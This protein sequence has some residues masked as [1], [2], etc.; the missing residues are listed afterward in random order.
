M[1][2]QFKKSIQLVALGVSLSLTTT[3]V[4][5]ETLADALVSAYN[6]SGLLEQNRALL[7]AADEDVASASSALLPILTWSASAQQSFGTNSTRGTTSNIDGGTASIALNAQMMLYDFGGTTA[8]IESARETV[9]ATRAQLQ[10]IEQQILLRGATAYFNLRRASKFVGLR[11]NNLRLLT[12][13][14]RA[15][16]D[17]FDVGEIT[18]TD[19]ALAESRLAQARSGLATAQGDL[20]RA[21]EEYTNVIGHQPKSLGKLPTLPKVDGNVENAKARAVRNHPSMAAAQHQVAAVEFA[22][23]RAEAAMKP[24]VSLNSSIGIQDNLTSTDFT[25]SASIGITASGPIYSGGRLSSGVRRAMAQRDAMRGNL[26]MVRHGVQ[27]SVGNA[28]AYYSSVNAALQA[29]Q[30]Q[31]RSARVAFRGVRE[32]ASL[33]ARTTIDVLNA[34]NELLNAETSVISSQTDQYIAAYTILSST[35]SLTA[36]KLGLKVQEYDPEAYYNLV[37]KGATKKSKQGKQLDDLLKALQKK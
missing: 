19:V 13:E 35:G 21:R 5:A 14:L 32:E 15:S 24:T 16:K 23:K 34:E 9:Y 10:S 3:A 30:Q 22:I 27:Q 26:H 2:A 36:K 8:G 28:Y 31:I 33:G 17:R 12:Q 37:K 7:R 25:N 29:G 4:R 18:R 11:Q 6:H 20:L 1:R